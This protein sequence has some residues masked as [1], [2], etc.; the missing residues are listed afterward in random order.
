MT[1]EHMEVS[2]IFGLVEYTPL[3]KNATLDLGVFLAPIWGQRP[4]VVQ[5][6]SSLRLD[7]WLEIEG[8]TPANNFLPLWD[9]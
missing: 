4:H 6:L 2:L 3:Q 9:C 8:T 7:L 1:S 5:K